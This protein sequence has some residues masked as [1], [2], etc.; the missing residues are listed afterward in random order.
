MG[1]FLVISVF[2]STETDRALWV[3]LGVALALA[4]IAASP[5]TISLARR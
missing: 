5:A 1:G 2:L 3:L 4:R